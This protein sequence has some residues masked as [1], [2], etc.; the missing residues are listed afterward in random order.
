MRL[1]ADIEIT[2]NTYGKLMPGGEAEVGRLWGNISAARD[3][4]AHG[5]LVDLRSARARAC[6]GNLQGC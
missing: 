5:A 4:D 3:L 1:L 6:T 2:F